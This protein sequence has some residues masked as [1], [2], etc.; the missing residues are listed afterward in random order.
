MYKQNKPI[1]VG[2]TIKANLL[3]RMKDYLQQ[4]NKDKSLKYVSQSEFVNEAIEQL[5]NKELNNA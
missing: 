1:R 2:M 5:L 4:I 3:K